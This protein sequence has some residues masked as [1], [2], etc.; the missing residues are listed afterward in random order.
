MAELAALSLHDRKIVGLNPAGS[1][2][3]W[4]GSINS[5]DGYIMSDKYDIEFPDTINPGGRQK[6][7][8]N[9]QCTLLVIV[10][11]RTPCYRVGHPTYPGLSVLQSNLTVSDLQ[12]QIS[13]S[14]SSTKGT[15]EKRTKIRDQSNKTDKQNFANFFHQTQ[16]AWHYH[17]LKIS[18]SSKTERVRYSIFESSWM[19]N[20]LDFKQTIENRPKW[21]PFFFI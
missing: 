8:L 5:I 21:L 12:Q 17:F 2:S 3:D 16:F 15:R 1:N 6:K 7:K 14:L 20:G 13:P 19:L 9:L 18:G 11:R 10:S 4:L